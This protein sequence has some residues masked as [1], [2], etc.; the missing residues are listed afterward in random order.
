MDTDLHTAWSLSSTWCVEVLN[1]VDELS[2]AVAIGIKLPND[3][4]SE[5]CG[6]PA[7]FI[8]MATA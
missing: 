8:P 2:N 1:I 7:K 4:V 5:L 6:A 3:I